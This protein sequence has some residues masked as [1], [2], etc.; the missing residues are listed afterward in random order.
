MNWNSYL[1]R[2][3]MRTENQYWIWFSMWSR[4]VFILFFI[5]DAIWKTNVWFDFRNWKLNNS[6]LSV[7]WQTKFDFVC[8]GH[9]TIFIYP[10]TGKWPFWFD[11]MS[12][13]LNNIYLTMNCKIFTCIW[14]DFMTPGHWITFTYNWI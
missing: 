9:R 7:S 11:F 3:S 1:F 12:W 2:Y 4:F 14:S 8:T 6:Y 5:F 13:I 10:W